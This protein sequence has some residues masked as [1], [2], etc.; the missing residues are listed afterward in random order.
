MEE[1]AARQRK[2]QAVAA[3]WSSCKTVTVHNGRGQAGKT[4]A[5]ILL[6]GAF[7]VFGNQSPVLLDANPRGNFAMRLEGP[8]A[9]RLNRLLAD[10]PY[11]R[12]A[13]ALSHIRWYA[14]YQ[15]EAHFDAIPGMETEFIRATDGTT[16]IGRPTITANDFGMI[17]ET[18]MRVYPLMIVDTGNNLDEPTIA[19]LKMSNVLVIPVSWHKDTLDPAISLLQDLDRDDRLRG[20][21][22]KAIIVNL[23]RIG[24]PVNTHLASLYQQA[25]T[26]SGHTVITIPQDPEIGARDHIHWSKLLP[27]TQ[28]AAL[29]LAAA[30]AHQLGS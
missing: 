21:A 2:I 12:T 20:L 9:T 23:D 10:V 14:I 3:R 16:R 30:V 5:A 25:F 13:N 6:A 28:N 15:T 4:T 22:A 8:S 29:S 1:E 18:L 7:G 11:L 17:W 19:A 26:D 24:D 27:Q